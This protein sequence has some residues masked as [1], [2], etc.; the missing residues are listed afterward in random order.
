MC[1]PTHV[2]WKSGD[3]VHGLKFVGTLALSPLQSGYLLLGLIGT[4]THLPS[5]SGDLLPV[6]LS[7]LAH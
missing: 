4:L 7:A 3:L 2:T 6:L 1:T 5:Q